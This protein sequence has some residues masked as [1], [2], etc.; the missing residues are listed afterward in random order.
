MEIVKI[1]KRLL[2]IIVCLDDSFLRRQGRCK[3]CGRC[4]KNLLNKGIVCF[5][6]SK[7]NKC[8][9]QPVKRF[10]P[11]LRELCWLAPYEEQI[12]GRPEE[13]DCGYRWEQNDES[14][15]RISI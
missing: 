14:K 3:A 2:K 7:D 1:V 13:K 4:C 6:L 12:N 10:T 15:K 11:I 8:I 5:F 9:L